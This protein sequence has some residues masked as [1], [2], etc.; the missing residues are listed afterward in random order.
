M[1]T[2][3]LDFALKRK[4]DVEALFN[5]LLADYGN[6]LPSLMLIQRT[7]SHAV[8]KGNLTIVEFLHEHCGA[9]LDSAHC[10]GSGQYDVGKRTQ[11]GEL[12]FQG[13][14]EG[15]QR[16]LKLGA[17]VNWTQAP[18]ESVLHSAVE[19]GDINII[20]LLLLHGAGIEYGNFYCPS[21][22]IL[23]AQRGSS[24]IVR[25]FLEAGADVDCT[26]DDGVTALMV[27][28]QWGHFDVVEL[29]LG[30]SADVN[31]GCRNGLTALMYGVQ[32]DTQ[33]LGRRESGSTR[34]DIVRLLL[35]AGARVDAVCNNGFTALIYAVAGNGI[36]YSCKRYEADCLAIIELLIDSG[37]RVDCVSG[38][39]LGVLSHAVVGGCLSVVEYL[40]KNRSFD[41]V[42]EIQGERALD[43]AMESLASGSCM[44]GELAAIKLL[45]NHGLRI[46]PGACIVRFYEFLN[47][48][49]SM[50]MGMQ[51]LLFKALV[52]DDL[53]SLLGLAVEADISCENFKNLFNVLESQ[54]AV[55][56]SD[57]LTHELFESVVLSGD[58]GVLKYLIEKAGPRFNPVDLNHKN[59]GEETLL[60]IALR[61]ADIALLR[62]LLNWA[63]GFDLNVRYEGGMTLLHLAYQ[64]GLEDIVK[65]LKTKGA[66]VELKDD[67]SRLPHEC[68]PQ[69]D[70][71]SD[72][73]VDIN[74]P[75]PIT[76][77]DEPS[78]KRQRTGSGEEIQDG[79]DHESDGQDSIF[80]PT[81]ARKSWG[82]KAPQ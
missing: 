55:S 15:V 48:K 16:L 24:G 70:G 4:K 1:G 50:T 54:G 76:E 38:A 18:L 46:D 42:L 74:H 28:A 60:R 36:G 41:G 53:A 71:V 57:M 56:L 68:V 33:Q 59:S 77:E 19:G 17:D 31:R 23:A 75:R 39:G 78:V 26:N 2:T 30:F 81:Y 73:L 5:A 3:A 27:A 79:E 14:I 8:S 44:G 35:E 13:N 51:I 62:V 69:E 20:K 12:A 67:L 9:N 40:L 7:L 58:I 34:L 21:A 64:N 82:R 66:S 10:F 29:L 22:L 80:A 47:G 32:G 63:P 52:G 43:T 45:I 61:H 37:A 49:A 65:Y 25:L 6:K 72:A 11:L